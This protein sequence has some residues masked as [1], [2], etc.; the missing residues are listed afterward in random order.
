M[1]S[2]N[3]HI[4]IISAI[5]SFFFIFSC[6]SDSSSIMQKPPALLVGDTIA[7]CA[8]SGFLDSVR[9]SLAK[10]RLEEKGFHIIREDSIYRRWGYLAGTD[11]QRASE[12]MSYFKDKSVRA[13]FPGTGGYGSTRIL[14]MLDYDII[15]SNPKIFIGF[16]DITALHIAFNQLANLITFHTPN[17]MYGLGSKKGLDPISELYFWSLLMNS[18]DNYEIP[19]DLYGDSLKVQTMVP[20]IASGKLVGGN[21]SLICSTMGSV[22]EAKTMG[23]ILFIEDVGEAPYRIDR[24]LSELKLAGK[25]DLV[26]GIIIG[27]FSRRETE[28]PDRSTDFQM[29]Q[30][31]QQYFSKMKV[32][33]IFNFPSGH[34]SKNVSLPLGCIVEINTDDEIFKVLES[35][36][37]N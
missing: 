28:A 34:G 24:Y 25:L 33:V 15:K 18:D 16:S 21:L 4:I 6:S 9:M 1:K 5:F 2:F 30:V 3:K 26:N 31:F 20:G 10:T 13:I 23:S 7:F 11:A 37:K 14:S 36:I 27:R 32:P 22:Y 17:P 8:P 19:F 12:L 35:P 29:H